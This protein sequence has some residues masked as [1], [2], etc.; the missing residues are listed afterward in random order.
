MA[1]ADAGA[2]G[3][4]VDSSVVS[5]EMSSRSRRSRQRAA[6]SGQWNLVGAN[7]APQVAQ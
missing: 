3:G 2:A 6:H 1:I 5:E 7:D 4:V